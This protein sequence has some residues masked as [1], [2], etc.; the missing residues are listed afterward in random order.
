MSP[1]LL[2][3]L[4]RRQESSPRTWSCLLL[5]W[6]RWR[7]ISLKHHLHPSYLL[8]LLLRPE[9]RL[10][11]WSL[12]RL[13]SRR[14]WTSRLRRLWGVRFVRVRIQWSRKEPFRL[15]PRRRNQYPRLRLR[16]LRT[17]SSRLLLPS[18]ILLPLGTLGV[19]LPIEASPWTRSFRLRLR[20]RTL[21]PRL[22]PRSSTQLLPRFHLKIMMWDCQRHSCR[23]LN[24]ERW[25]CRLLPL[26]LPL[27]CQKILSCQNL[28]PRLS[29]KISN[30]QIPRRFPPATTSSLLPLL[31]Q[32]SHQKTSNSP[33]HP[34]LRST[35]W[36]SR[37][38]PPT[39][40]SPAAWAIN[41]TISPKLHPRRRSYPRT[42]NSPLRLWKKLPPWLK[43]WLKKSLALRRTRS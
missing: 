14:R 15:H 22:H 12:R 7:T 41:L 25:S 33:C 24:M 43:S 42:S 17:L 31:L 18:R 36:N 19:H 11:M 16:L 1:A 35:R 30:C 9:V 37:P 38:Q 32:R 6:M 5:L 10:R 2:H 20:S 21:R 28:P 23:R 8:H 39:K 40:K 29:M 27:K 13:R 4:C 26:P 34:T 3:L